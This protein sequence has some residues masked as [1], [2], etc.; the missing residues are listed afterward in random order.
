VRGFGPAC[1]PR[2]VCFV[3]A[4]ARAAVGWG[5][6]LRDA[7]RVVLRLARTALMQHVGTCRQVHLSG[8]CP[9]MQC[10]FKVAECHHS[11]PSQR[12]TA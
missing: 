8:S 11:P 2:A 7:A 9:G 6:G 5:W 12:F 1:S 3:C 4:R 10:S